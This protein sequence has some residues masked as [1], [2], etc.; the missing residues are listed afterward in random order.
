MSVAA[1]PERLTFKTWPRRP[2][3][4]RVYRGILLHRRALDKFPNLPAE[5]R[6]MFL[7]SLEVSEILLKSTDD[8]QDALEALAKARPQ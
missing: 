8:L 3:S 5:F 4:R 6:A 1:P 7:R 2:A